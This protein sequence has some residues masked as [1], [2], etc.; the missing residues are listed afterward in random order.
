MEFK[1]EVHVYIN[2]STLCCIAYY[3]E[4][5]FVCLCLSFHLFVF[6]QQ[7]EERRRRKSYLLLL[8]KIY[9][10]IASYYL[11]GTVHYYLFVYA[12]LAEC[13]VYNIF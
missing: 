7:K 3:K 6:V 13:I 8:E 2:P 12:L 1:G 4:Y 9:I 5:F 10:I 11:V